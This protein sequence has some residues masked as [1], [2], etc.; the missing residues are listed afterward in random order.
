MKPRRLLLSIAPLPTITETHEDA[1]Q[2]ACPATPLQSLEEYVNSI[3]EL[4]Q[5]ACGPVRMARTLRTRLFSKPLGKHSS[6]SSPRSS[7]RTPRARSNSLGLD[8]RTR[9]FSSQKD[10][11]SRDPVDWLFGQTQDELHRT[12]CASAALRLL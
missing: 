11:A 12:D 3:K 1:S 10:W 9:H 6:T 2:V 5:P 8:E 7:S 4:A